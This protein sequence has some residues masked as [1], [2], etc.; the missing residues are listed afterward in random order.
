MKYMLLLADGD[1]SLGPPELNAYPPLLAWLRKTE[2][3]GIHHR[4]ARLRPASESVTV[5]V[6]GGELVVTD[7]PY[8]DTKEH[9]G[10]FGIIECEDLDQAI[11]VAGGHPSAA[12][13]VEIRPFPEED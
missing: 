8:A 12:G 13:F 9:V 4:G 10:G 3:A 5:R 7:G 6:R 11:E 2:E 1:P